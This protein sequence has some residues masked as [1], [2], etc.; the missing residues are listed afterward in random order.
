M[1]DIQWAETCLWIGRN[2]AIYF[3]WT[4]LATA[5]VGL[6]LRSLKPD[7]EAAIDYK[8]PLPPQCLPGW[9]GEVL[10]KPSL[11]VRVFF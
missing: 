7:A 8:V 5:V 4:G 3:I 1:E 10:E 6:V 2:Y 11:K 9:K